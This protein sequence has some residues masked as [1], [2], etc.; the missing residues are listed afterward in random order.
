MSAPTEIE[1][2]VRAEISEVAALT[3]TRTSIVVGLMAT[4]VYWIV[5]NGSRY[6]CTGYVTSEGRFLD[7][8]GNPLVTTPVCVE[9][10]LQPSP[11]V[12]LAATLIVIV[13]LLVAINRTA[14]RRTGIAFRSATVVLGVF[15]LAAAAVANAWLWLVPLADFGVRSSSYVSPILVG[16]IGVEIGPVLD[17]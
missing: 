9:L 11:L 16:I 12:P 10:T 7:L 3:A 13:A 4:I 2:E 8:M 15:P 5:T 6:F 17:Q 1:P 14:S